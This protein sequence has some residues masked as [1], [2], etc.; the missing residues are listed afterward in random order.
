MQ[1][2]LVMGLA[3][4]DLSQDNETAQNCTLIAVSVVMLQNSNMLHRTIGLKYFIPHIW[5]NWY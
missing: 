4:L 2:V 1:M 3:W 5:R